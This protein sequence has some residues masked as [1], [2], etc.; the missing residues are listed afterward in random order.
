MR[1]PTLKIQ[2]ALSFLL[3]SLFGFYLIKAGYFDLEKNSELLRTILILGV[4]FI[5]F[6]F[7]SMIITNMVIFIKDSVTMSMRSCD[8][9]Q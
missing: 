7:L 6:L 8:R 1:K 5:V 3:L 4:A 2:I 9:K